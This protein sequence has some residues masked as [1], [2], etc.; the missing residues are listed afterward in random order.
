MPQGIDKFALGEKIDV[1]IDV[2]FTAPQADSGDAAT[3]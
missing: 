1:E 3:T 2:Q